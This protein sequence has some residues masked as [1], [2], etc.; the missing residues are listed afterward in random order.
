MENAFF[1]G[2]MLIEV[3]GGSREC[4][5]RSTV[6]HHGRQRH[7]LIIAGVIRGVQRPKIESHIT[8]GLRLASR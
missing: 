5:D 8:H 1:I 4:G 2:P 7:G 3:P 6:P